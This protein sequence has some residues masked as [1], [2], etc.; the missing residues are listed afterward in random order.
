[1]YHYVYM[2]HHNVIIDCCGWLSV[3]P[4]LAAFTSFLSHLQ[5]FTLKELVCMIMYSLYLSTTFSTFVEIH[6]STPTYSNLCLHV[7]GIQMRNIINILVHAFTLQMH[8][9]YMYNVPQK[10]QYFFLS[11]IV[12]FF[13]K[14]I[15]AWTIGKH[16]TF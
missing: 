10:W 15:V 7:D 11:F 6:L 1:M 13:I 3:R 9:F 5:V 16:W 4:F 12:C 2:Y 8:S 14:V